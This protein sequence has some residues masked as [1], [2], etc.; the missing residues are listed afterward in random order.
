MIEECVE[1]R[2][3]AS[4]VY[5]SCT[6]ERTSNSCTYKASV[7]WGLSL[8]SV[9]RARGSGNGRVVRLER[10]PLLGLKE[11]AT[12]PM[13]DCITTSKTEMVRDQDG[14][15]REVVGTKDALGIGVACGAN[16]VK[17]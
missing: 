17:W 8:L 15:V 10:G 11:T 9:F 13:K 14:C 6:S 1:R 2:A 5:E 16:T 3:I 7:L 12:Q 4:L